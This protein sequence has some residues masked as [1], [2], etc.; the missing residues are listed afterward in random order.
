MRLVVEHEQRSA[1]LLFRRTEYAVSYGVN[2][3]LQE[4]AVIER[5]DIG[6]VVFL[7]VE[8]VVV[9]DGRQKKVYRDCTIDDLC[10][11]RQQA[12]FGTPIAAMEFDGVI[13]ESFAGLKDYLAGSSLYRTG[14]STVRD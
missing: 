1:G 9:E 8:S 12:V 13:Q 2:F 10:Q 7:T 3:T 11:G 5:Y 6:H 14:N 4:L